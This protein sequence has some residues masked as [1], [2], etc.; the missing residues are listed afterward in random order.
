MDDKNMSKIWFAVLGGLAIANGLTI[1][2]GRA[3][4]VTWIAVLMCTGM[5][6]YHATVVFGD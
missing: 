3:N 5:A 1:I 6:L 2:A 4:P